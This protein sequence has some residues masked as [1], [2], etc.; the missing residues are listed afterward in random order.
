M[1]NVEKE[2]VVRV[3]D[4]RARSWATEVFASVGMRP[5]DAALV[6]DNLVTADCRGLMSHGLMRTRV[7]VKR[8]QTGSIDPRATPEVAAGSGAVLVVDGRNAMGQVV[9]G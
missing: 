1:P 5:R 6:A 4:A 3:P 7:Y 2:E 8:L 9:V